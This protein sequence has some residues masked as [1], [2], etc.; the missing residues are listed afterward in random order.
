MTHRGQRRPSPLHDRVALLPPSPR[1]PCQIGSLCAD[2][3]CAWVSEGGPSIRCSDDPTTAPFRLTLLE[4][5]G[6][7][8]KDEDDAAAAFAGWT[9]TSRNSSQAAAAASSSR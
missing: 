3:R 4:I 8:D 1:L 9:A 5:D 7:V 6:G 2:D